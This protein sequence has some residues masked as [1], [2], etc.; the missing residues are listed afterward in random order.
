MLMPFLYWLE[1]VD[2][3][4]ISQGQQSTFYA[5]EVCLAELG[6][7]GKNIIVF[8]EL[9]FG[10]VLQVFFNCGIKWVLFVVHS[11]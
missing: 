7:L 1:C 6:T 11:L 3:L 10:R 4:H 9:K 2:P 5:V 8:L